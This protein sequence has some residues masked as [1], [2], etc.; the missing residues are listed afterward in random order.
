M[1]FSILLLFCY[2]CATDLA[3]FYEQTVEQ[4]LD[5]DAP[6]R[7]EAH[8]IGLSTTLP[9]SAGKG[10]VRASARRE[11]REASARELLPGG[12]EGGRGAPEREQGRRPRTPGR[13]SGVRPKMQTRVIEKA[14]LYV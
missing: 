2:C 12:G 13:V 3:P 14:P 10:E 8:G 1:R 4:T 9:K 5:A 6:G 7:Q 11:A